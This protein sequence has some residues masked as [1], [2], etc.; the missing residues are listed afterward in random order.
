MPNFGIQITPTPNHQNTLTKLS[1]EM[2]NI[3][4]MTIWEKPSIKNRHSA[5][6]HRR[7]SGKTRNYH[8][9]G[10]K[11]TEHIRRIDKTLTPRKQSVNSTTVAKK[12][13]YGQVIDSKQLV[14][15]T[16][17]LQKKKFFWQAMNRW[18]SS[19]SYNFTIK[20]SKDLTSINYFA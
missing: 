2:W 20:L 5:I 1:F 4:N 12:L 13:L 11:T 18:R 8:S 6:N 16:Q 7:A 10:S 19:L 14:R 9:R 17:S 3:K 15:I